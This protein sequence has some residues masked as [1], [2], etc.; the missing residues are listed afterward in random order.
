[1]LKLFY[2]LVYFPQFNAKI[3]VNLKLGEWEGFYMWDAFSRILILI[4]SKI[5]AVTGK[6][7][8]VE[9]NKHFT[10][11]NLGLLDLNPARYWMN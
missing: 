7:G 10:P 8:N 2:V 11:L 5:A 4:I 3:S 1:M 6:R 9:N